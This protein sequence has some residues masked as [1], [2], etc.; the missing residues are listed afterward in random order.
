M[1]RTR[2]TEYPN[3]AFEA[4]FTEA[5]IHDK[6]QRIARD[7]QRD[8]M[9]FSNMLESELQRMRSQ[10]DKG[11]EIDQKLLELMISVRDKYR[12][13]TS[14]LSTL[15]NDMGIYSMIS[16]ADAIQDLI[17]HLPHQALKPS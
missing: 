16:L 3:A 9:I 7:A 4:R 10:A 13:A 5:A 15:K 8:L 1:T 14:G 12:Y 6:N 2:A 17:Y 11:E